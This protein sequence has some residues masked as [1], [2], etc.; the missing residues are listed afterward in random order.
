MVP[1]RCLTAADMQ[2]AKATFGMHSMSHSVWCKCKR[3]GAHHKYPKEDVSTYAEVLK[4]CKELGCEIKTHDEL[5]SWAHYSPGVAKGGKFTRFTCSCCGY[6]PNEKQWRADLKNFN[7]MTDR[8]QK[9]RRD[10]HRDADDEL[11]KQQQHHHQELFVPPMV[12]HG[13]ERAGVDQLH[14]VFLNLF[15]HLFKYTI[16]EGLPDSSKKI[17]SKY[18]KNAGFY[19]Y[20]AA[21][22]DED[23]VAHWIGR[24]VKRFL[25]EADKH[26]PFL[27]Q[28]A[29]APADVSAD[30]A[31]HANAAGHQ[32]MDHDDEY[33]PTEEE[34]EQEKREEPL[35]MQNADRWDRFLDLV[36]SIHVPWPQGEQDTTAY[37]ETRAV[38]A[39]NL[40]A[41][42]AND[43]LQLKPTMLSW[44]PHIAVFVVPRQMVELGDPARRSADACESFGAMFKKLIKHSTCRRRMKGDEKTT[45]KSKATAQA[46]RARWEQTFN[47]GYI[48]QAFT[49]ACVR[50]SLQHG[51]QNRP[52]RQRVDARRTSVGKASFS[53]KDATESP[54]VMR[55]IRE[56]CAEL[57][58]DAKT[59]G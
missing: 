31:Q 30:M 7:E 8:E 17:I 43:L 48:E 29:A 26:L 49:R 20:D 51:E 56:L 4:Y 32:V 24:E 47:R 54:A 15:K 33:E 2:G 44:V 34:L 11:N 16:H 5:C 42:V 37:R 10:A 58:E 46:S 14:L 25:H 1:A 41:K 27:L 19:S 35:M 22:K 3:G 52:Y 59:V 21:S 40:A 12:N 57:P 38:E 36:R 50:E 55:P 53:R 28:I 13:M 23:P 9:A 18:L 45:H 39:F 6:S